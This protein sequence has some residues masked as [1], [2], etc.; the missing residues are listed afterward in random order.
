MKHLSVCNRQRL[1]RVASREVRKAVVLL[2]EELLDKPAYE[3]SIVFVGKNRMAK[4]N[5]E[6]L[7]HEGPTD[8]ITFHYRT[9]AV[10]HGEL[11]ICP[12]VASDHARQYRATLGREL[13]RYIIHGVLHLNGY[14][15]TTPAARTKMKR[16]ENRLLLQLSRRFPLDSLA[17]G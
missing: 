3:L 1:H 17:Y 13:A 15:D 8:I 6:H 14:D 16:K 2:M 7:N 10:L 4:L 12:A 5:K 9:P 11:V